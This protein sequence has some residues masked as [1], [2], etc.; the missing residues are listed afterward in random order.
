MPKT[1]EERR[2]HYALHKDKIQK[3][4]KESRNRRRDEVRAVDRANYARH[5]EEYA[6]DQRERARRQRK[7]T[8]A[9]L[10]GKCANSNCRHLN[11]D[12]TLGCTDERLLQ[13]DHPK[14]DGHIERKKMNITTVWRKVFES[15]SRGENTYRLLCAQ[16]NWL[17]RFEDF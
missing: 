1:N 5:R 7:A 17:H 6:T 3:Q 9:L 14:K 10:G 16:C 13:I 2:A 8:V 11:D 4:L 15:A 12:G